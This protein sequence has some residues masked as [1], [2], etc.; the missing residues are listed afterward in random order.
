MM[1]AAPPCPKKYS[2]PDEPDFSADTWAY[3]DNHS[4]FIATFLLLFF[5]IL[6]YVGFYTL[7]FL[8]YHVMCLP[9]P[10]IIIFYFAF[11]FTMVSW[12]QTKIELTPILHKHDEAWRSIQRMQTRLINNHKFIQSNSSSNNKIWGFLGTKANLHNQNS[13]ARWLMHKDLTMNA[14]WSSLNY[15]SIMYF[16]LEAWNLSIPKEWLFLFSAI[17]RRK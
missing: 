15:Q 5:C 13:K 1:K 6:F 4:H 3:T 8:F 9:V 14:W 7:C 2:K 16:K 10:A 17:L 12:N 11:N